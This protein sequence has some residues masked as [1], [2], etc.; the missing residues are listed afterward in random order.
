MSREIYLRPKEEDRKYFQVIGEVLLQILR[1][2]YRVMDAGDY[3]GVTSDKHIKDDLSMV[4]TEI[5][6]SLYI[7]EG[8]EDTE[9]LL[10]SY[11]DD[12]LLCG[13][14]TFQELTERT[15]QRFE[16]RPRQWDDIGFLGVHVSTKGTEKGRE[17]LISQPENVEKV[18]L[19]PTDISFERFRSIRA[20]FGWFAHT[21]PDV[22]C[23]IN[24]A[25]QVTQETFQKRHIEELNKAIKHVHSSLNLGLQY[26]SL[27]RGSLH[28]RC[29]ADA[30][31]A[32][33][34]DP[35]SQLGYI[36]LLCDTEDRCHILDYASRKCKRVV[37]SIMGG[38]IYA[39][40]EGFD[41]V[42]AIKH[43]LEKVY[44]QVL[45]ITVPTDSK[46][47]FD[48]ITKASHTSEKRLMID[49][50]AAREAYNRHD[51]SN[52][53]LVVS[54]HNIADGLTKLGNCKA[55]NRV[56]QTGYDKNPVQQW[57]FPS[58]EHK[59]CT[60]KGEECCTLWTCR[61]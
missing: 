21:R 6:P 50:A 24:R 2:L 38:E 37:R 11:V 23:A 19:V 54:E 14:R 58:K 41:S 8:S 3:W 26:G 61:V 33:K 7:K 34:D 4:P 57:I 15:L 17:F 43:T 51:I 31:F 59:V 35:F 12:S 1:A 22:C 30:S 29:Y 36:T 32:S 40:A 52:V 28:L 16:S 47:M 46:Q 18:T 53:G 49:V 13:D 27:D 20:S 25:A 45:P 44:R 60:S 5:N 9:G 10:G 56:M 48:V 55:P 42:Y 39:F